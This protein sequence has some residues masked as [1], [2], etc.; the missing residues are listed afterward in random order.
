MCVCICSSYTMLPSTVVQQAVNTLPCVRCAAAYSACACNSAYSN[1]SAVHD[2]VQ[3]I[4]QHAMISKDSK[5]KRTAR[6]HSW[7]VLL[8]WLTACCHQVS[9]QCL[10]CTV[11]TGSMPVYMLL[12][13]AVVLINNA[14]RPK[15]SAAAV[16]YCYYQYYQYYC[17]CSIT[18]SSM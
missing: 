10:D 3:S 14:N 11:R 6:Q 9:A 12:T 5:H 13:F 8:Q 17:A 16:K 7:F 4:T 2:A 1:S 15:Y 18:C